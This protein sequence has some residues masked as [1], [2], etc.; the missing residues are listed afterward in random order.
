[1]A[2]DF[3][4]G[5]VTPQRRGK[6]YTKKAQQPAAGGVPDA[7]PREP[8]PIGGQLLDMHRYEPGNWGEAIEA[9]EDFVGKGG[10]LKTLSKWAFENHVKAAKEDADTLTK[11]RVQ[12]FKGFQ[13]I[14]EDTEKAV[15][16]K[17]YH[18]AQQNRIS[19]PWTKFFYYDSLAQDAKVESSIKYNDWASKNL[20]RLAKVDD[21]SEIAFELNNKANEL[22]SKYDYLPKTFKTSVIDPA[23]G[24][25][26][27]DLK[28]KIVQKRLENN[29]ITANKTGK[30]KAMGGLNNAVKTIKMSRGGLTAEAL[31]MLETSFQDARGFLLTYYGG[32]EKK[33][34]SVL[35]ELFD[36][37]YIDIDE[38][39]DKL[40]F[41]RND[42]TETLP[43]PFIKQALNEIKTKDGVLFLDLRNDKGKAA[44]EILDET[45]RAAYGLLDT[46]EKGQLAELKR[47][48]KVWNE[49]QK[50]D[51]IKAR[52]AFEKEQGRKPNA[53]ELQ[54]M[55]V[56]QI[57]RLG[58]EGLTAGGET[59]ADAAETIYSYYGAT[60]E[61]PTPTQNRQL[62]T[63]EAE[64]SNRGEYLSL[65]DQAEMIRFGREDL[66]ERN[67]LEVVKWRSKARTDLRKDILEQLISANTARFNNHPSMATT[68]LQQGDG[69]LKEKK[70]QLAIEES[71][72]R[73]TQEVGGK[74][75]TLINRASRTGD[76]SDP[77]VRRD[78]FA[79]L[80]SNF[81]NRPQYSDPNF[82]YNINT[83]DGTAI[84]TEYT[85][86][87][88]LYSTSKKNR[89]GSWDINVLSLDNGTTWAGDA[90]PVLKGNLT[91]T[92]RFLDSQFIFNERQMNEVIRALT[93][94]DMY[95]ISQDTRDVMNNFEYATGGVKPMNEVVLE[96]V[97]RYTGNDTLSQL[98]KDNAGLLK[99]AFINY[100]AAPD[101]FTQVDVGLTHNVKNG[102]YES[103]VDPGGLR[104]NRVR[105][106]LIRPTGQTGNNPLPSPIA[107]NVIDS[108]VHKTYGN[109][110]IVRAEGNGLGYRKGDR[111][112]ISGG[113]KIA[114][115]SGRVRIGDPL[116]LT[117]GEGSVTGG[118]LPCYL[119][120]TLFGPGEGFPERFDQK[121]QSV[122]VNFLEENL[123]PLIRR[124]P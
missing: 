108:G 75:D 41:G 15:K 107:G 52:V 43:A 124:T 87:V 18:A 5:S 117:G 22:T 26:S 17:D 39:G 60:K 8:R 31:K 3:N 94:N 120:M 16:K 32:D 6:D 9:I 34:N 62:E 72:L 88:P 59:P 47:A 102:D 98:W 24:V 95:G 48:K 70:T 23:M 114:K 89:D 38:P 116:M 121:V 73:L 44:R 45:Y 86:K 83:P 92:Q 54:Q 13:A 93:T 4:S 85:D 14:S 58:I 123:Y 113:S 7:A 78:I 12:A 30:A 1:M 29:D 51:A 106:K 2:L 27:S 40:K 99:G 56:E 63:L 33:A 103:Y 76:L 79:E 112:M 10:G 101:D 46:I 97:K 105:F 61:K 20:E 81:S 42:L 74:L 84:G 36:G 119:Q 11:Q 110:I 35:L 37:L 100:D 115:T 122:Q 66:I 50:S 64:K 90:M 65:E 55:A 49:N 69:K 109:Y 53:G 82:Y 111:I 77:K 57:N 118:L 25:I 71:N 96:Q 91:R 104:Y 19:D 68:N 67:E 28:K 21:D 80:D